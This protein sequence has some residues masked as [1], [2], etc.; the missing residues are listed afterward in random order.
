MSVNSFDKYG[1]PIYI[2]NAQAM[3]ATRTS[4]AFGVGGYNTLTL[5]VGLSTWVSSTD[6][7]L[8]LFFQPE[9]DNTNWYQ[10]TSVSVAA[11]TGTRTDYTDI[12]AVT[13]ADRYLCQFAIPPGAENCRVVAVAT[14][15][16]AGDILSVTGVLSVNKA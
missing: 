15:S 14:G 10:L 1:A 12:Y 9:N 3:G 8:T 2:F 4:G 5:F 6:I 11:G 13:A 16:A 7:R